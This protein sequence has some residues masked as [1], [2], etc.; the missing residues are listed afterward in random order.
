MSSYLNF[1]LVPKKREGVSEEPKPLLFNSYSRA[2][3]VYT[4]FY[5]NLRPAYIGSGDTTNYTELTAKDVRRVID[6]VRK[7][8][9]NAETNL[10]NRMEAYKAL[11]D[12][13][14]DEAVYDY[15]STKEY[16]EELKEN[17][18]DL[19]GIHTW[20]EDLEYSDF[21]KVLINID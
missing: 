15:T 6:E 14:T 9:N 18:Y 8:L 2:S 5:E 16:I 1:Y 12:K 7:D 11:S 17:I 10:K 13:P 4:A 21:E 20:I 3:D 19:E